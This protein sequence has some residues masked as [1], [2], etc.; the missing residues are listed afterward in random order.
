[1]GTQSHTVLIILV[2]LDSIATVCDQPSHL[3]RFAVIGDYGWAGQPGADVA[4]MVRGWNPDFII[5][6][7]TTIALCLPSTVEPVR[8]STGT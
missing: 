7:R 6:R 2:L 3:I 5:T 8:S 4:T 1:M